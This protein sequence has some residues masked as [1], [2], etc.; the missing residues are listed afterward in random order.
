MHRLRHIAS[1]FRGTCACALLLSCHGTVAQQ[2]R[3]LDVQLSVPRV[4]RWL[5][6]VNRKGLHDASPRT[7]TAESGGTHGGPNTNMTPILTVMMNAKQDLR[8]PWA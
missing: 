8:A 5:L 3:S 4:G 2:R 7:A 6:S 1:T